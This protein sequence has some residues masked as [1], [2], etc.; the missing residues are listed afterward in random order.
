MAESIRKSPKEVLGAFREG[1]GQI[2]GVWWRNNEVKEKVKEKQCAYA[3]LIESK[4][5]EDVEVNRLNYKATKKIAKR[6]VSVAKDN[7]FERLY[8]K[9]ETKEGE[10]DVFRLARATEKKT[11]DLGNIRCIKGDDGKSLVDDLK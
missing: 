3:T 5:V 11:R 10:K 6:V 8:R 9:M 2:K 4:M 1:G 7:S